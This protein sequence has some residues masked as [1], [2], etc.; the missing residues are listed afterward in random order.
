MVCAFLQCCWISELL[1]CGL[2]SSTRSSSSTSWLERTEKTTGCPPTWLPLVL[3]F[4]KRRIGSPL[5]Y[6][7]RNYDKDLLLMCLSLQVRGRRGCGPRPQ[8]DGHLLWHP[9]A[10]RE[11]GARPH[12]GG[13]EQRGHHAVLGCMQQQQAFPQVWRRSRQRIH[14][15]WTARESWVQKYTLFASN[16]HRSLKISLFMPLPPKGM[17]VKCLRAPQELVLAAFAQHPFLGAFF[18]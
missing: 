1:P 2:C 17:Y 4:G 7:T 16:R 6:P 8:H 3:H 9:R 12:A 15:S 10:S 13:E 11:D 5:H 18:F 14:P